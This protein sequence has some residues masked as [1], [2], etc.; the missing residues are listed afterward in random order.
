MYRMHAHVVMLFLMTMV[1]HAFSISRP[2]SAGDICSESEQ[3]EYLIKHASN[4]SRL[5]KLMGWM[6]KYTA[7]L[8][9]EP[10]KGNYSHSLL[11]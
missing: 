8:P 2:S 1:M 7:Y 11:S 5:F 6:E 10:G 3:V 9:P 4:S